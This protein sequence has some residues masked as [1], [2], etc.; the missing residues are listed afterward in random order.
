MAARG[1]EKMV[2]NQK[3]GHKAARRRLGKQ[4]GNLTVMERTKREEKGI[5][6][7]PRS[8]EKKYR[9]GKCW[10]VKCQAAIESGKLS[11]LFMES[12]T[13]FLVYCYIGD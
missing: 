8:K 4:W 11:G 3:L 12:I 6:R 7:Q 13:K 10:P 5:M 1:K 9:E 2:I